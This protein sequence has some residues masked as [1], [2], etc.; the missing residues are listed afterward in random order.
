MKLT[1]KLE[2]ANNGLK[3]LI[4]NTVNPSEEIEAELGK[5]SK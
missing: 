4:R 1:D 5:E 3:G 2:M